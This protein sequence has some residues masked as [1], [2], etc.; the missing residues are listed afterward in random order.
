MRGTVRLFVWGVLTLTFESCAVGPEYR[1]PDLDVPSKWNAASAAAAAATSV[2]F[3]RWWRRLGDDLLADLI[4]QALVSSPDVRLA[5]ERLRQARAHATAAGAAWYPSL[6]GTASASR[7][8]STVGLSGA[9][10][11]PAAG[12]PTGVSLVGTQL[13]AGFDASWELDV[14][15]RTRRSVQAAVADR[16]ASE[17]GLK[18]AQVTLTAEVARNYYQLRA[19]QRR[20]QIARDNLAS[21]TETVALAD[22]RAQA[23]LVSVQDVEQARA[24]QLQTRAQLPT[25][26]TDLA[27]AEYR[28][29]VLLGKAP[30]TLHARLAGGGAA[31]LPDAPSSVAVAIP[32]NTLRQRPDIRAA[33]RTLAAETAR[34][35]L[36]TAALYPSFT[37]S[38][39]V[40]FD[41]LSGTA[42]GGVYSLLAGITAPLFDGGKLRAQRDEQDAVCGQALV[43]YRK[44]I[45]TALEEVE[46]ALLALAVNRERV[47]ALAAAVAAARSAAQLAR[48]RYTAGLIDFQSVLDTD[49][50][51][52]SLEDNLATSRG[53]GVIDLVTLYKALG[54]GW[55]SAEPGT[56][57]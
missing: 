11:T 12:A 21:Q 46:N 53:D 2:D 34:V 37:L 57:S 14:F 43:T 20:L 7:S 16:Q 22:Y 24:N 47:A 32:A 1:K 33:E 49:R 41:A 56:A 5:Q 23:G 42:S 52:L 6:S 19:L 55:S 51:V 18:S 4:E 10:S 17:E 45:L 29:D 13:Q 35:G 40:G 36:A 39:T 48:Q 31:A 25:L 8:G 50:T 30:G 26:E 44:T 27:A 38:G 28:L 15:G 54:G 3:S 9:I